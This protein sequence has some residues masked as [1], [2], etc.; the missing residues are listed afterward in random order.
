MLRTNCFPAGMEL[1]PAAD[2]EQ[3]EYIKTVI[4]QSDYYIIISAGRYGTIHPETGLSFT[5]MEFDYAI[6]TGKPVV[7][8]L[9]KD[10][11][12]K[13]AGEFIEK[14]DDGRIKLEAFRKKLTE[15]RLVR[16]WN[17][18]IE[19]SAEV[20][21]S[22]NEIQSRKPQP[23]WVRGNSVNAEK[24]SEPDQKPKFSLAP[25][26]IDNIVGRIQEFGDYGVGFLVTCY[27]DDYDEQN[28]TDDPGIGPVYSDTLSGPEFLQA[29]LVEGLD[30]TWLHLDFVLEDIAEASADFPSYE[31]F[32]FACI[33]EPKFWQGLSNYEFSRVPQKAVKLASGKNTTD[34]ESYLISTL[35]NL[36]SKERY[37]EAVFSA[38][39]VDILQDET[40]SH[41]ALYFLNSLGLIDLDNADDLARC[42]YRLTDV[43]KV[44]ARRFQY[45][46]H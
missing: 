11:F 26:E 15:N 37:S 43:G 31:D 28:D 16:F 30:N 41:R 13:L 18:P 32:L 19:L 12:N 5:E 29:I 46:P 6:E 4:D 10:P 38:R 35:R 36:V 14:T 25:D 2:E 7:R 9:H 44:V 1:F 34:S 8:L 39:P 40:S 17:D 20:V 24:T 45:S 42:N 3:F 33:W 22:M 27:L 21:F 23:G